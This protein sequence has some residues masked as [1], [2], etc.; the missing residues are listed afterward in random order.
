MR[1]TAT[2]TTFFLLNLESHVEY[3]KI[4]L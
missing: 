1:A 2:T 3:N 4:K